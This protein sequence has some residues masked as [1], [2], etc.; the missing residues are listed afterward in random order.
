M[1]CDRST[2]MSTKYFSS[3]FTCNDCLS[4]RLTDEILLV[5]KIGFNFYK[6]DWSILSS[7]QW[8]S[9]HTKFTNLLY[10]FFNDSVTIRHWNIN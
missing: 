10:I 6:R 3:I 9:H 1:T 2:M 8:N 5:E 7:S 4:N